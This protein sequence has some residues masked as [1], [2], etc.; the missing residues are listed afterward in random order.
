[1]AR[2]LVARASISLRVSPGRV[3]KAL[4]DPA[5]IRKYLFGTEVLSEW[6]KGSPILYRGSWEGKAY[7]DKGTILELEPERLFTSTYWSSMSGSADSPENYSEVSWAI[8]PRGAGIELSVTQD[9]CADEASRVHSQ[10]NWG[11][12]LAEL[13]KLVED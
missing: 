9:N 7:E 1:M 8:T 11:L 13:K 12:V 6:K 2:G 10:A 3:W 4:T 5:E